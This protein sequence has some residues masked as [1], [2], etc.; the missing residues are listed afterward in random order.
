[1]ASNDILLIQLL[2]T[3]FAITF[4]S[5]GETGLWHPWNLF[6]RIGH[7]LYSLALSQFHIRYKFGA[8]LHDY[9]DVDRPLMLEK[10][11]PWQLRDS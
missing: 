8:W 1:M 4:W 7:K 3:A 2:L 6:Q 5:A 9:F 10:D 11:L